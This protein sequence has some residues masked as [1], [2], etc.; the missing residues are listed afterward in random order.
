[1]RRCEFI[2]RLGGA[3]GDA[4]RAIINEDMK[5]KITAILPLQALHQRPAPIAAGPEGTSLAAPSMN[6][7]AVVLSLTRKAREFGL[8]AGM[9]LVVAIHLSSA[10]FAQNSAT[11]AL[12]FLLVSL[13]S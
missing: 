10:T 7:K 3:G 4:H 2:I 8:V 13:T 12:K 1:M 5:R 11:F 6:L 9:A